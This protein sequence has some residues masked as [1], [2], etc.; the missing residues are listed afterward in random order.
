VEA[1][2]TRFVQG[3]EV[4][5]AE[6]IPTSGPLILAANH[7]GAYDVTIFIANQ[8]REDLK[9]IASDVNAIRYLPHVAPHFIFVG[10]EGDDTHTRM[11]AFRAAERHLRD[12]GAV[13]LFPT[14]IVNP[15][16]AISPGAHEALEGWSHSLELFMHRVPETRLVPGIISGVISPS[17]LRSPLVRIRKGWVSRQKLAEVF[18]VLQQIIFPGSVPL[19][20][21]VSFGQPLSV[22]SLAQVGDV[23]RLMPGIIRAAQALLAEHLN[24]I[25]YSTVK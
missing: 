4:R 13:F 5:G 3:V 1:L 12:G 10:R 15:D 16:P 21:K 23:N 22:A 20:P 8:P 14:G 17:W 25:G 11:T 6:G 2:L 18:E 24:W 19:S 7:P 9:I